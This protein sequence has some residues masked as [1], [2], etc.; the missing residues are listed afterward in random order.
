MDIALWIVSGV[1]AAAYVLA[2]TMKTFRPQEKLA[3]L[4][5]TQHY[6]AGTVKFIGIAELLGGIGLILPWLT[7]IAP[8]LTPLAASGLALVQA[9]AII[10]H[11]RHG[12]RKPLPMNAGLLLAA[13]FVAV[14]RF[15]SL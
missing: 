4:P 11:L 10:H 12:E 3:D 5:W 1:L 13:L 2:G 9:L 8:V 6:S 15:A 14:F 7:G